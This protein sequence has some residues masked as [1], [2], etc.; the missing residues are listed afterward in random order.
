VQV[1]T[2]KGYYHDGPPPADM[3]GAL[4]S[5]NDQ[6]WRGYQKGFWHYA[7]QSDVTQDKGG[8]YTI[9]LELRTRIDRDWSQFQVLEDVN[10]RYLQPTTADV[11][12]LWNMPYAYNVVMRNGITKTGLFPLKNFG[13]IFGF[14]GIA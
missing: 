14:G 1:L 12:E 2:A 3:I 10:G 9:T 7:G 5:V 6:T 11:T 8:S 13:G 4:N